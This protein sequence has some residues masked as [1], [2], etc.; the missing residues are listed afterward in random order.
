MRKNRRNTLLLGQDNNALTWLIIVNVIV[1]IIVNFIRIVYFLAYDK[2]EA[3]QNF[4]IQ[5]LDWFS[6]TASLDKLV[7][8]PWTMLSFM[9]THESVWQLIGTL[10]WLWAFGYIMQDLTGNSKLIPVYIYGALPAAF[11]LF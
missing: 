1:F 11:F 9:F 2:M 6:L 3:V 8:R 10:L 5:I 7:Y 4:H